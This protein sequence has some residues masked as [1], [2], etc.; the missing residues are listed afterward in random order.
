MDQPTA[1]KTGFFNTLRQYMLPEGARINGKF[2]WPMFKGIS[3]LLTGAVIGGAV[4]P[5]G[6]ALPFVFPAAAL[7]GGPLLALAALSKAIEWALP[8]GR[9]K[10]AVKPITRRVFAAGCTCAFFP[11][12]VAGGA[13][14]A[15]THT[16]LTGAERTVGALGRIVTGRGKAPAADAP[17]QD[18]PALPAPDLTQETT[19]PAKTTDLAADFTQAASEPAAEEPASAPAAAKKPRAPRRKK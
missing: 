13:V 15:V 2:N 16:A 10:E 12:I 1:S 11:V 6:Y 9:A 19:V 4:G 17:A 8:Q 3:S 18:V 14:M 5:M 7:T